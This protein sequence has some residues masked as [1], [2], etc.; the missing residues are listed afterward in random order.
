M[1]LFWL[2]RLCLLRGSALPKSMLIS[3]MAGFF[4]A[5]WYPMKFIFKKRQFFF[6]QVCAWN[7]RAG[8]SGI[9]HWKQSLTI[10]SVCVVNSRNYH[11]EMICRNEFSFTVQM[12]YAIEILCFLVCLFVRL[13]RSKSQYIHWDKM[14]L[15][16]LARVK[17]LIL[18][19]VLQA[20]SFKR[21]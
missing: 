19:F 11:C 1:I 13:Y 6:M 5:R 8:E 18:H 16:F 15:E 7:C 10:L 21:Q 3:R 2:L 4:S 9:K 14:V 17:R 12:L 20:C